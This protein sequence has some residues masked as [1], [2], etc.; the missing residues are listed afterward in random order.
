VLKKKKKK[1]KKWIFR[2]T[3]YSAT[4]RLHHA[5]NLPRVNRKP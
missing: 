3:P 2:D 4:R 1:K 5:V